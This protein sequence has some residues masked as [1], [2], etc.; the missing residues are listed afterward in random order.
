MNVN[1][2]PSTTL[3]RATQRELERL[4]KTEEKL[5]HRQSTLKQELGEIAERLTTLA[6]RRRLLERLGEGE[7]SGQDETG[8][9]DAVPL[10]R[11]SGGELRGAEI[12]ERAARQFYL[13]YGTGKS[14]H[15]RRWF[16]VLLRTGAEVGGKDPLATFLTN[17]G[18][19]PI[20]A[21]GPEPGTY[22]IEEEALPR[23]RQELDEQRAEL[24]DL[25]E[26]IA[27]PG[28]YSEELHQHQTDLMA[29]VRRL[30]GQ[31]AEAE[32]VLAP[33]EEGTGQEEEGRAA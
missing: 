26:V 22:F 28:S 8:R 21:R 27:R 2:R 20:V 33:P 7:T 10:H 15:Y 16:D 6:E 19:S 4:A 30:E 12:R 9:G 14:A 17:L 3:L 5:K 1:L 32:R 11:D 25:A 29:G 23:L 31:I 18:R 24:R 13:Q